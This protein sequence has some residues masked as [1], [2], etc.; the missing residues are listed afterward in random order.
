MRIPR[1]AS[2]F[3]MNE[4]FSLYDSSNEPTSTP[5]GIMDTQQLHTVG[6]LAAHNT[7]P[8]AIIE[9]II[10]AAGITPRVVL[11][12]QRQYDDRDLEPVWRGII[13]YKKG[14]D[15]LTEENFR[16]HPLAQEVPYVPGT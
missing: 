14:L 2:S 9:G 3:W 1:V 7:V 4:I 5:E 10:A 15:P 16:T 8:V 11:N 12:E 13:A 6:W